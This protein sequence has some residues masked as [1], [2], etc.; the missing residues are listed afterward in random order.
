M[1]ERMRKHVLA[2][3]LMLGV[4]AVMAVPGFAFHDKGV[5]NCKGCHTMHN[6]ENGV[7]KDATPAGNGGNPYLLIDNTASDVCLS[8]HATSRGA[9]WGTDPLNPPP[10]KGSGN[11]V[12]LQEDNTNDAYG[13]G[14]SPIP[15]SYAG[16]N[17]IAVSK[18]AG[19]D[20]VLTHAPGG[21]YPSSAL[22]CSSCHDPH[23]NTNFRLLYG[24]GPVK[25]GNAL[26]TNPAPDAIGMSATSS[27]AS[28]SRTNHTAYLGG[29]SAWC[30]NCHGDYHAN[31]TSLIHKSGVAMGESIAQTYN[32]YNGTSDQTGAVAATSYIPE[33]AFEDPAMT[34][35]ST[36]GPT[37]SSQVSCVSCHRAHATSAPNMG[38][39]DFNVSLLSA[40]GVNS[41]SYA[42]PNP[43]AA[44]SATTQRSLCNKCHNKDAHD[45]GSE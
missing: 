17:I 20:P 5:A 1:E 27:S 23:G 4:L 8:C 16:H 38:R 12:F 35:S 41:G 14:T 30:A 2:V 44:T 13:G 21:N 9:V 19:A 7:A 34:V 24:A 43:Y 11:F 15:G 3:V 32:L 45:E 42:M 28:E 36:A 6:S 22:G 33:V 18:N 37:A 10:Q 29:M 31:G 39:W 40:D 25:A 26:F